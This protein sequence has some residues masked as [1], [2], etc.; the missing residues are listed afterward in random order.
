MAEKR[1]VDDSLPT[2]ADVAAKKAATGGSTGGGMAAG[3]GMI[4]KRGIPREEVLAMGVPEEERDAVVTALRV[5]RME[6][7]MAES[8][9]CMTCWFPPADCVCSQMTPI[10]FSRKNVE[11]I[12]YM[13]SLELY[14][15]GDDAKILLSAAP[16]RT[17]LFVFG[18]EGD[19]E[20]LRAKLAGG[21]TVLLF[22]DATALSAAE[23]MASHLILPASDSGDGG[24]RREGGGGEGAT[25]SHP[26]LQIMVLDG[27]WKKV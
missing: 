22:P 12:V 4:R 13:H 25:T 7:Q 18:R 26:P 1:P 6:A 8:G 27:T 2:A 14:N 3:R 24:R 21:N 20:K 5:R 19:D 9:R 15:V 16:S 10:E 17:S 11:F 23:A